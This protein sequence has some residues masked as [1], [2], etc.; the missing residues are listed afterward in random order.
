[1]RSYYVKRKSYFFSIER[2][3]RK[4][5]TIGLAVFVALAAALFYV[6]TQGPYQPDL[7]KKALKDQTEKAS[8]AVQKQQSPE[9][10][11]PP[12][13]GAKVAIVIDDVGYIQ[14]YVGEFQKT[15]IPLT[16]SV[17]PHSRYGKAHAELFH[18]LGQ[19]IILHLPMENNLSQ[20]S[21]GPGE[22]STKMSDEQIIEVLRG[23]LEFVPQAKGMNNHE[24]QAATTDLRVMR[25][26]INYCQ[27]H[28]LFFLDSLTT[29]QSVASQ[30]QE[31]VGM[32]KRVND[33]F[34]DNRDEAEEVKRQ[35]Q[36]LGDLAKKDGVAIGIGHIQRANTAK[37]IQEM[38]PVLESQ[39][40]QFVFLSQIPG[41]R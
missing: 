37:A 24:G 12:E 34:I 26:V 40:V 13:G 7:K 27:D 10:Q 18:S 29:S 21:Y 35:I 39:G 23:D 6:G 36:K 15:K 25:T 38:A 3:R 33:W 16:F 28:N 32:S 20:S 9:Q 1:M 30:V 14:T 2:K 41:N 22:I 31:E 4:R 8:V 11:L 5:R 19:E 17:L